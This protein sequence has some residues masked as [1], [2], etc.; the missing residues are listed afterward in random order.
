MAKDCPKQPL[1]KVLIYL[2]QNRGPATGYDLTKMM[3]DEFALHW[4]AR[5]QQVYRNLC[6]LE[7]LHEIIEHKL[8]PQ[9]GKPDKK[10]YSLTKKGVA[11]YQEFESEVPEYSNPTLQSEVTVHALYGNVQYFGNLYTKL[12][13]E[14]EKLYVEKCESAGDKMRELLID[15]RIL[16]LNADLMFAQQMIKLLTEQQ[17]EQ[18]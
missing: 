17:A 14:S 8:V 13:E 15:R 11:L 16:L 3:K 18:Q 10:V 7:D 5:H 1:N 2:I 9:E 6:L 12:Y 4:K